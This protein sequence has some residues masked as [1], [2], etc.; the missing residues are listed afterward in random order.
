MSVDKTTSESSNSSISSKDSII[1]KPILRTRS[2]SNMPRSK[3]T[4][5]IR[6]RSNSYTRRTPEQ[7]ETNIVNQ[8]NQLLRKPVF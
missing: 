5:N 8:S 7:L 6:Q 1:Q 2:E 4:T 3:S